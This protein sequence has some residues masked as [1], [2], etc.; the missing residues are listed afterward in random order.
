M[1]NTSINVGLKRTNTIKVTVNA[2]SGVITPSY[3]PT[4]RTNPQYSATANQ[5]FVSNLVDVDASDADSGET[6]IY[7]K[8]SNKYVVEPLDLEN[9]VGTL[10]MGEF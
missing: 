7:H 4:I 1:A 6:L 2:S 8:D 10:D 5:H 9:T 3:P